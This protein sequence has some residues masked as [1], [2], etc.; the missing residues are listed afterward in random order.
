M[1]LK[2][3]LLLLLLRKTGAQGNRPS[4]STQR[5]SRRGPTGCE[6]MP[7]RLATQSHFTDES[8]CHTLED[9]TSSSKARMGFAAS[10]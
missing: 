1:L 7:S 3:M 8:T 5:I 9:D 2:P 10:F 4:E 6:I